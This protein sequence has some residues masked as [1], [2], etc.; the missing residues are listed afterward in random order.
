[1]T[2]DPANIEALVAAAR[3]VRE[4]AYAPYSRFPVGAALLCDDGSIVTGCNVENASYSLTSCA[5]RNAVF[6]AIA[7]GKSRF[8]AIAISSDGRLVPPCGACRQVL[9][10]FNTE[11]SVILSNTS[12]VHRMYSLDELLPEPFTPDFLFARPE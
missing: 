7:Q 10:E 5:E 6:N 8:L 11:M 9:S 4:R 3:E 1:M 2:L 12:D